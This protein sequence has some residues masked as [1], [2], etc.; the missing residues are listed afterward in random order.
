MKK[1]EL[2]GILSK[3]EKKAAVSTA[4]RLFLNSKLTETE[5]SLNESLKLSRA[6]KNRLLFVYDLQLNPIV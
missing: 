1:L 2:S 6:T 5:K 3:S 4:V